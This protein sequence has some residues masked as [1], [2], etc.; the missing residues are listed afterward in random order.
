MELALGHTA[1]AWDLLSRL[2]PRLAGQA[3]LWALR[4]NAA[5]RLSRHEDSVH[6]YME[7]LQLRPE[8]QRWQL[9]LA[10]SLAALGRTAAAAEVADKARAMGPISRD[11]LAY[12]R[13]MGVSIK[14]K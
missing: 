4:G 10:V 9:G 2:E 6:S 14:D 5:Q 8:E 13:Q 12:L 11:V 7:A 1:E 3:D